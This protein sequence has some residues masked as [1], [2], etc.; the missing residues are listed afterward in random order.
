MSIV[1]TR[2]IPDDDKCP[3]FG[4][5]MNYLEKL[6]EENKWIRDIFHELP[7]DYLFRISTVSYKTNDI[8]INKCDEIGRAH[9]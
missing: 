9:V 6:I 1:A 4:R 3:V 5:K 8:V 2:K 7:A